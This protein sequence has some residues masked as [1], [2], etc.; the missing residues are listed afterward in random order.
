[1][2]VG[3]DARRVLGVAVQFEETGEAPLGETGLQGGGTDVIGLLNLTQGHGPVKQG[4]LVQGSGQILVAAGMVGAQFHGSV[5]M[6]AAVKVPSTRDARPGKEHP[7]PRSE[8]RQGNAIAR[9]WGNGCRWW[10]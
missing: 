1:M 7:G 3:L 9:R 2:A 6:P 10:F 4:D 5:D 8:S